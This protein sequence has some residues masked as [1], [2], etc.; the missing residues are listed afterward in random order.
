[1]ADKTVLSGI[2]GA[3][4]VLSDKEVLAEFATDSSFD[5]GISPVLLVKPHCLDEIREILIAANRDKFSIIPISSGGPHH[6]GDTVPITEDTVMVDLSEMKRI[7]RLDHRNKIAMIEPGVTF[8]ELTS[9]AHKSGLRVLMPLLPRE[10][11]SVLASCLEREPFTIPKYQW[12]ATDP[13]MCTEIV[14]GTSDIYR[15]GSAAGPGTIEEQWETGA[16]QKNPLGPGQWDALRLIQGAQGTMGIVTWGSVKLE[17]LPTVQKCFFAAAEK[18]TDLIDFTYRVQKFKLVDVCFIL[19]A[20]N[21]NAIRMGGIGEPRG[22]CPSWVLV[23]SIS[24][25]EYFPADRVDYIEQE[26][27]EIAGETAVTPLTEIAGVAAEEIVDRITKSCGGPY[28]KEHLR[29]DCR[30]IF[31]ITTLDRAPSFLDAM[32]GEAKHHHFPRGNLGVYIQPIQQG[33]NCHLEFNLM[34]NGKSADETEQIRAFFTSAS[35]IFAEMGAFFSR[36]YGIWSDLAYRRAPK[37]VEMLQVVKH[38]LDP[39][40][41]MN[42]GKLCFGREV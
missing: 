14:F 13:L 17:L 39:G 34:F 22:E 41:I 16:V 40:R 3:A 30:D 27:N 10:T 35:E 15:T 19:N 26:I 11:K 21:L 29:G 28:W 23:Y 5:A 32:D 25:Y 8:D 20:I 12:D 24:G 31:F 42:P 4:H 38:M 6:H 1:M 18:L 7:V 33:R 2:V 36:P 37:T 9:E